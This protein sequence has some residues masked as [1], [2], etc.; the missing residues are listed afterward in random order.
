LFLILIRRNQAKERLLMNRPIPKKITPMKKVKYLKKG[1]REK[2]IR[3]Q[4]R[5]SKKKL[6]QLLNQ[7]NVTPK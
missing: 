6:P 5:H 1:Q 7:A 4:S 3:K 2:H